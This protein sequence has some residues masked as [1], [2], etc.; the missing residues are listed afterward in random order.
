MITCRELAELLIDYVSGDLPPEHCERLAHHLRLCPPCVAYLETY[1][2]T[3]K[4]TRRLPD[5]PVPTQ[6]K[7]RLRVALEEMRR[8]QA[9]G[10]E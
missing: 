7:E 3:I 10:G 4:L 6:L 9:G 1:R 8:Q 2:L 5:A